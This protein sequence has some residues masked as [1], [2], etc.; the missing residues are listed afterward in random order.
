M[1][2]RCKIP[3]KFYSPKYCYQIQFASTFIDAFRFN[4]VPKRDQIKCSELHVY[5]VTPLKNE[6]SSFSD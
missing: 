2:K 4:L 1:F 6:Q 3:M 5:P